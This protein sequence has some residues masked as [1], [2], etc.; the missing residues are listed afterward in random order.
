MGGGSDAI[1]DVIV[2]AQTERDIQSKLLEVTAEGHKFTLNGKFL[3]LFKGIVEEFFSGVVYFLLLF[4]LSFVFGE[5]VL[6][7]VE[8][9]VEIFGALL[10]V[11]KR[12]HV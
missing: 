8:C 7:A 9:A 4:V 3:G 1:L 6:P 10:L 2:I 11:E 5:C 12:G